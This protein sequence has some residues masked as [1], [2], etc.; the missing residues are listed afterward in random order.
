[1]ALTLKKKRNV[2]LITYSRHEVEYHQVFLEARLQ[3]GPP[4]SQLKIEH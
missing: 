4:K 1:M 3:Q 2:D